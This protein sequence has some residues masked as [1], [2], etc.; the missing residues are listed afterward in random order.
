[1]PMS[2]SQVKI[3]N[4]Y[5]LVAAISL[6][7]VFIDGFRANAAE[8]SLVGANKVGL[9]QTFQ[10]D[11]VV[12]AEGE[13][14]NAFEGRITYDSQFLIAK[15][16]RDGNSI[17]SF[18]LDRPKPPEACS[19]SCEIIFSGITPGG[20]FG[21]GGF[22]FAIIF[23]AK[24][25]GKTEIGFNLAKVLRHDG[26]GTPATL[27]TSKLLLKISPDF[28]APEVK[29]IEDVAPP[30]DFKPAI[31]REP[32]L[33]EG[34]HFFVFSTQD[35]GSGIEKYEV[36]ES[37]KKKIPPDAQWIIAQ[38]PYL[39]Q[40]QSLRSYIYVKAVDRK[41]NERIVMLP[42]TFVPVYKDYRFWV[43]IL[44]IVLAALLLRRLILWR[45][46]KAKIKR[47]EQ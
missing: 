45:T 41:G 38:S 27:A 3:K 26:Q 17:V 4:H 32:T 40:D 29:T 19:E 10:V 35:K 18:W 25:S 9:G 1:M 14:V 37:R 28:K 36:L 47:R 23:E 21:S 31:G 8:L 46:K 5:F 20:Y 43:I 2:K 30:E 44:L 42:P 6:I 24:R 16:M 13:Y 39:L 7:F 11:V 22:L 33:F 34:K 15:E 12:N